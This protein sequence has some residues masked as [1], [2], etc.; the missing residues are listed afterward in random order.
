MADERPICTGLAAV[1]DDAKHNR[2]SPISSPLS[3]GAILGHTCTCGNVGSMEAKGLW[4]D[5]DDARGQSIVSTFEISRC[6]GRSGMWDIAR[7][8]I[9]Y[10]QCSDTRRSKMERFKW[11]LVDKCKSSIYEDGDLKLLVSL[12]NCAGPFQ[13]RDCETSMI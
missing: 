3:G 2:V 8:S 11:L 9:V 7:S 6:D 10:K 13:E 5:L 1:V 4:V 12:R